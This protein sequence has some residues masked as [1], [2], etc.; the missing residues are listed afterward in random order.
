MTERIW[1]SDNTMWATKYET[2]WT[3]FEKLGDARSLVMRQQFLSESE[4]REALGQE[5]F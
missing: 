2:G 4:A 1:N 5:P 3:I